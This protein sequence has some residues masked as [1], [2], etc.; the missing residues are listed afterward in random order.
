MGVRILHNADDSMAILYCSTS[1]FAF[2]PVFHET[3]A[4]MASDNAATFVNWLR[5]TGRA[6]DPRSL[7]DSQLS[8]AWSE[9]FQEVSELLRDVA[10][11]QERHA[12]NQ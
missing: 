1:D 5:E 4:A 11:E 6:A 7:N 3:D 2:G 8:K 10:Q 9:W 12:R